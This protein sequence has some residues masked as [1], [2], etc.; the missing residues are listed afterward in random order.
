MALDM[1]KR[2]RLRLTPE[3]REIGNQLVS[4][5]NMEKP[6]QSSVGR[7]QA[8]SEERLDL[9]LYALSHQTRRALLTRLAAG[10][11][12]VRELAEPFAATRAA[13]SKHIRILE[14][15]QLVRRAVSGRV[16]RCSISLDPLREIEAW[17]SSNQ[18][19][20]NERLRSLKRHAEQSESQRRKRGPAK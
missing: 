5:I 18:L 17:L 2:L 1:V 10:S 11:C 15:A 3:F 16:H 13:I 4:Y 20:W 7:R 12:M 14:Q 9:I 8:V 19:F 6:V